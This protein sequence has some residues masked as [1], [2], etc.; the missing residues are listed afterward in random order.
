[1]VSWWVR[2]WRRALGYIFAC[3]LLNISALYTERRSAFETA[4]EFFLYHVNRSE[5]IYKSQC[6]KLL[7]VI[8]ACN[9]LNVNAL[10]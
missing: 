8:A 2:Y 3:N 1:M 4:T 6:I 5:P 7:D 9:Q 10:N